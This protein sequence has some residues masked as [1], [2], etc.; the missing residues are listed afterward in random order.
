M[1]RSA[2]RRGPDRRRRPGAR[3]GGHH[4]CGRARVC[5]AIE[6]LPVAVV[7]NLARYL[8]E[9]KGGDLWCTVQPVTPSATPTWDTDLSGGVAI[10]LGA[11]G[12][13]SAPARAPH[14]RRARVDP[15]LGSGRVAE[16]VGRRR[17][18][19]VRST[20]PAWL[21]SISSTVTTSSTPAGSQMRV[22]CAM[23]S[24]ATSRSRCARDRR[25]RR[26]GD[27][28]SRGLLEVR[29]A[30]NADAMLERLAAE[31]RRSEHVVRVTSDAASQ[32]ASAMEARRSRWRRSWL[33][34]EQA[35]RAEEPRPG[36]AGKLDED[37]CAQLEKLRQAVSGSS[38][39]RAGSLRDLAHS[40]RLRVRVRWCRTE[41]LS[42]KRLQTRG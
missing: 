33:E 2:G 41:S 5:G 22:S 34:L 25:L 17:S 6:H 11:G 23:R 28:V 10:V 32:H 29:D 37:R 40:S 42:R 26:P 15:A 13:G 12:E 31:H 21:T 7:T 18:A 3:L 16:R 1:C 9:V 38:A 4:A 20:T 35:L 19:L 30:L 39:N 14:V 27:L 8:E 36:L 24:R